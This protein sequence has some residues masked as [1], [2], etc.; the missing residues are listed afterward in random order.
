M[1]DKAW[2][3]AERRGARFFKS[4]RN[5]LSG[6]ASK[7][8]RS[9]SLHKSLFIEQKFRQKTALWTLYEDTR[10][11]ARREG[12]IPVVINH[13]KNKPGMLI[14]IHSDDMPQ[15][16]AEYLLAHGFYINPDNLETTEN[17]QG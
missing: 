9:D 16:V 12:K 6:S 13:T 10:T 1:T 5:P 7:H 8:T 14:T 15:V 2:K 3:A 4:E 17:D 11:K